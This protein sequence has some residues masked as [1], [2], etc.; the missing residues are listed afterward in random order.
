MRGLLP[1][2]T[3]EEIDNLIAVLPMEQIRLM[4]PPSTGLIMV[5]V[6]DC[7]DTEFF[8]GEILVTRAEVGFGDQRAQAT[9]LG[10]CPQTTLIAAAL[11]VLEAAGRSDW[12]KKAA[13]VYRSARRRIAQVRRSQQR[14]A[15]ATRVQF[16]S[17]AEKN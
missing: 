8:L 7:F 2:M 17:M 16:E 14:L 9:L 6:R 10:D 12:I 1:D 5:R 15:S 11:A 3:V 4:A 13:T